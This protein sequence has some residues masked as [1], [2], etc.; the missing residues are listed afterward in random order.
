MPIKIQELE[1]R[2]GLERASIRFYEKEGLLNPQRLENGYREYSVED[3][4]LL[5]KIKLL[6][7]CCSRMPSI[8]I[9]FRKMEGKRPL[10]PTQ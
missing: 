1:R 5:K 4:E 8:T 7:R 10:P 2:T 3:S 9:S 6:R